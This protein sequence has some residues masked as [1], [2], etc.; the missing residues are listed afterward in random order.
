MYLLFCIVALKDVI[1]R[2]S[3]SL[4]R[5]YL[6]RKWIQIKLFDTMSTCSTHIEGC[7]CKGI[8][9]RRENLV[10]EYRCQQM[11][12]R[13]LRPKDRGE[14]DDGVVGLP[15]QEVGESLLPRSPDHQVH[16]RGGRCVKVGLQLLHRDL[17]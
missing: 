14:V 13:E 2:D 7:E 5:R 9:A 6:I 3:M 15:E 4:R 11:P 8:S 10:I 16:G 1:Q 17:F 12:Q